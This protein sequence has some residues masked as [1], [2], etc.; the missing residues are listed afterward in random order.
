M[1][2]TP[3]CRPLLSLTPVASKVIL[4]A[5]KCILL[6]ANSWICRRSLRFCHSI[7]HS[8]FN[9]LK[10]ILCIFFY[11]LKFSPYPVLINSNCYGICFLA[12]ITVYF[13][14]LTTSA[15]KES[16]GRVMRTGYHNRF[17][18]RLPSS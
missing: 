16:L 11:H 1:V 17:F 13:Y 5:V 8:V 15:F 18:H 12:K 2:I 9:Y 14:I 7:P 10:H 4:L 3:F 6:L